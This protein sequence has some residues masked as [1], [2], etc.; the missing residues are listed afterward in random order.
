MKF[1]LAVCRATIAATGTASRH[2]IIAMCTPGVA[3]RN[4]LHAEPDTFHHTPFFYGLNGILGAGGS[5]PARRTQQ[6]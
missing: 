5:M 2:R 3:A 1:T 6:R 4:A